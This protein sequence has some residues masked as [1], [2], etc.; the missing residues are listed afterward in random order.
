M[1]TRSVS[2]P[3]DN[4]YASPVLLSDQQNYQNLVVSPVGGVVRT[5]G[6]QL[7]CDRDHRQAARQPERIR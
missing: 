5:R 2:I 6:Q 4:I 7:G 1:P 3:V